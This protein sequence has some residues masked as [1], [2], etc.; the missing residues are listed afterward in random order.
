MTDPDHDRIVHIETMMSNIREDIAELVTR[1]EFQPVKM[2]VF[3]L[4]G[5]ILSGVAAA[6]IAL[7]VRGSH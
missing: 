2:V 1:T 6:I 7:V 3:G 4:V 5:L